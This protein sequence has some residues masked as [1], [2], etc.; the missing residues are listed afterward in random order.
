M[1]RRDYQQEYDTLAHALVGETGLSA[2]TEAGKH[3]TMRAATAAL[4][5]FPLPA[6]G[7]TSEENY[8]RILQWLYH[9]KPDVAALII[10]LEFGS[11]ENADAE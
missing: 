2:I 1:S 9:R 11:V 10:D 7:K 5:S 3:A 6:Q 8:R 4:K